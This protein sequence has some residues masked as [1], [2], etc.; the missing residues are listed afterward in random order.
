LAALSSKSQIDNELAAM[1]SQLALPAAAT[2]E[3]APQAQL[4]PASAEQPQQQ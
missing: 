2:E 3:D 1:K 4:P